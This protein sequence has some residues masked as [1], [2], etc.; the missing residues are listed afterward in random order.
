MPAGATPTNGTTYADMA[1]VTSSAR[2]ESGAE[3]LW[4]WYALFTVVLLSLIVASFVRFHWKRG[5]QQKLRL[6]AEMTYAVKRRH[7]TPSND[8]T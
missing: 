3:L 8:V 7:V 5:Q 6:D 4:L 1:T 2:V